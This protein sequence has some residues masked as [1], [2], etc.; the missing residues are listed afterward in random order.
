[1]QIGVIRARI[2]CPSIH[3]GTGTYFLQVTYWLIGFPAHSICPVT[4][5]PHHFDFWDDLS[6]SFRL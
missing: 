6:K 4:D 1:M 3:T 5:D 2:L